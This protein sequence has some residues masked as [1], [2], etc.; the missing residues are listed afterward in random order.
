MQQGA[1]NQAIARR[2]GKRYIAYE[3]G[4][5]V[6]S[7]RGTDLLAAI[8]RDPRMYDIYK[9]Y[10]S[11]WRS[12]VND[13]MVLY[14]SASPITQWGAWGL[15]EYTGQPLSETPKRRAVIDAG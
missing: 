6:L 4:Q 15:R 9:N 13:V 5:H 3:A 7:S 10:I 1:A 11:T 12:Q 14:S 2:F 8:N